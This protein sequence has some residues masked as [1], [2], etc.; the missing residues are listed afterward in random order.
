MIIIR[1]SIK[2]LL[3]SHPSQA[4]KTPGNLTNPRTGANG[5]KVSHVPANTITIEVNIK[6]Q[7]ARLSINGGTTLFYTIIYMAIGIVFQKYLTAAFQDLHILQHII[8][9]YCPT[10]IGLKMAVIPF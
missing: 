8:F 10:K 7:L 5:E 9:H 1:F 2:R 4:L 3:N 6:A